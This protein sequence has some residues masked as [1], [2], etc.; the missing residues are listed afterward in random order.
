VVLR[1]KE[2]R[3]TRKSIRAAKIAS[4]ERSIWGTKR[5]GHSRKPSKKNEREGKRNELREAGRV[6]IFRKKGLGLWGEVQ[7]GK[8]EPYD[9]VR[10]LIEATKGATGLREIK[11]Y[12]TLRGSIASSEAQ[13]K[14][15]LLGNWRSR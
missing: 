6:T 3:N 9:W 14:E 7:Y 11:E 8:K 15:A 13:K 5:G 2:G 10:S 12:R 1:R 4:P